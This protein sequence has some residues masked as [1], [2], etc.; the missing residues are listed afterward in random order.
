[1]IK[2]SHSSAN[3][4][5][6]SFSTMDRDND[7][8]NSVNC[9]VQYKGGWWFNRSHDAF[10]N[11]PWP[12]EDWYEPWVPTIRNGSNIAEV[13]MMIKPT[14]MHAEME[15]CK[16]TFI[17]LLVI[18]ARFPRAPSA[19]TFVFI[20]NQT[21]NVFHVIYILITKISPHYIRYKVVAIKGW[22]F[23]HPNRSG[24]FNRYF[25]KKV[26]G[27]QYIRLKLYVITVLVIV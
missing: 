25:A 16:L 17:Y 26:V 15:F 10:L 6:T 14:Q 7:Q 27:L 9:A 3:L 1:M 12:P 13:R 24:I 22:F 5:G 21:L 8:W 23:I 4:Y 20:S 19:Q 18:F 11:G 2:A